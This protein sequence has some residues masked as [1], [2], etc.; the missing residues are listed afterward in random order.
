MPQGWWRVHQA[1][2]RKWWP[3]V[4]TAAAAAALPLPLQP[5]QPIVAGAQPAATGQQAAPLEGHPQQQQQQE[6]VSTALSAPLA[7]GVPASQQQARNP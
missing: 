6:G 3:Q 5:A 2:D 4:S 1:G 7:E